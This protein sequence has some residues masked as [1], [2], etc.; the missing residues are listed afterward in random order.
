ML[1]CQTT[2]STRPRGS[3]RQPLL[4]SRERERERE[5]QRQR[6]RERDRERERE[7]ERKGERERERERERV[8]S[9]PPD[10]RALL[11]SGAILSAAH[12]SPIRVAERGPACLSG[13]GGERRETRTGPAVGCRKTRVQA[14]C[15]CQ[16]CHAVTRNG[17]AAQA[18]D[19]SE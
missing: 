5:R 4:A 12:P 16:P 17:P 2:D 10:P 11:S 13:A 3:R 7:R 19:D 15:S 18:L 8:F 14:R 1:Y 6:Q 9:S